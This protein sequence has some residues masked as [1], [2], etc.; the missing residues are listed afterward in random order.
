MQA[1][2]N[3]NYL[4]FNALNL[5]KNIYQYINNKINIRKKN[6]FNLKIYEEKNTLTYRIVNILFVRVYR[7]F[8]IY[9]IHLIKLRVYQISYV[10]EFSIVF[11]SDSFAIYSFY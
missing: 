3:R 9:N 5:N 6:V 7:F 2:K 11:S 4:V 8:I 1:I 10:D